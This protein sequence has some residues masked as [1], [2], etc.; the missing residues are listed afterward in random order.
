MSKINQHGNPTTISQARKEE[1]LR[2]DYPQSPIEVQFKN[3]CQVFVASQRLG[4]ITHKDFKSYVKN[5]KGDGSN[6]SRIR[7]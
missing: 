3:N 1:L 6:A 5:W 7:W 4:S 2:G